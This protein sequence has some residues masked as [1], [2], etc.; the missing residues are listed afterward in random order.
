VESTFLQ[1][2]L[3]ELKVFAGSS[4]FWATFFSVVALFA[5]TGPYQTADTMLFPQRLGYWFVLHTMTWSIAIACIIVIDVLLVGRIE[6]ILV[7]VLIAGLLSPVPIGIAVALFSSGRADADLRF[8]D[9]AF[10]IVNSVPLTLVFSLLTFM[11]MG[12]Q[13]EQAEQGKSDVKSEY[14]VKQT[15]SAVVPNRSTA[16]G[17][18]AIIARLKPDNRGALLH[19]AV[20]DHYV[21]VTTSRGH[22]LVLL[23]FSDALKEVGDTDGLQVHRSHWVAKSF[24]DSVK[25]ENGKVTLILKDQKRIPVSRTYADAVRTA[26]L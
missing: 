6:S 22:E 25:R 16:L 8:G 18:P 2:A 10:S 17:A 3:R 4:R 14:P 15:P 1:T 12:T 20:E 19:M 9:Y 24:V 11:T 23:R 13:L 7:R 5:I 26:F 21:H